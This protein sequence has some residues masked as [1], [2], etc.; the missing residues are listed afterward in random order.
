MPNLIDTPGTHTK[1]LILELVAPSAQTK[2]KSKPQQAKQR[3]GGVYQLAC[4]QVD[5]KGQEAINQQF[6]YGVVSEG[7]FAESLRKLCEFLRKFAKKC[8]LLRHESL[9]N[10]CGKFAEI[11]W[12]FAENFLQ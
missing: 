11:S 10:F 9:R 4:C 3:F 2:Y 8:V 1:K 6:T 12:K 7:V 5:K